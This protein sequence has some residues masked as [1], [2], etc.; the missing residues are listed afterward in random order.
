MSE[1]LTT[2]L[3]GLMFAGALAVVAATTFWPASM[4]TSQAPR[5]APVFSVTFGQFLPAKDPS[6]V[7]AQP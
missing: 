7:P 5:A 6:R 2:R 3:Y 4:R 1:Q